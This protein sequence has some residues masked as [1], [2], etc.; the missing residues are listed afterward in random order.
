MEPVFGQDHAPLLSFARPD[1]KPVPT[2]AGRAS[3]T[4]AFMLVDDSAERVAH[5]RRILDQHLKQFRFGGRTPA[6]YI[7]IAK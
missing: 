7:R 2:F 5:S 6:P 3:Q 1:A 4:V